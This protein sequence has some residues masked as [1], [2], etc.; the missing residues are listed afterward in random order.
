MAAIPSEDGDLVLWRL[1][2]NDQC[3]RYDGFAG[4]QASQRHTVHGHHKITAIL[5]AAI[6]CFHPDMD[7]LIHAHPPRETEPVCI[8]VWLLFQRILEQGEPHDCGRSI[9]AKKHS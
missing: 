3:E 4:T 7:E 2:S 5:D 8:V 6:A 9:F 1:V